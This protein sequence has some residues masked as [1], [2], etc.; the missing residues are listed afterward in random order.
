LHNCVCFNF[1]NNT[2]KHVIL[3]DIIFGQAVI[4]RN[5]EHMQKQET[6]SEIFIN[7]FVLVK[8]LFPVSFCVSM[9]FLA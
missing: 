9:H 6:I 7:D 4:Q 3:R 1:D 8:V 2:G 5:Y